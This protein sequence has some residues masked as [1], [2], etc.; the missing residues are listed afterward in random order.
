MFVAGGWGLSLR[1]LLRELQGRTMWYL[2]H[3]PVNFLPR[4]DTITSCSHFIDSKFLFSPTCVWKNSEYLVIGT[5]D[6]HT[7]VWVTGA[8]GLAAVL[9]H[10][11]LRFSSVRA[12]RAEDMI[13]GV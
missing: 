4:R 9:P 6:Y 8:S 10:S 11:H 3:W 13:C 12:S 7:T 5:G 1:D 2:K